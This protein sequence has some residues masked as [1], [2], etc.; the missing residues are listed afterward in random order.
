MTIT[1]K[2]AFIL[3]ILLTPFC[4]AEGVVMR[5]LATTPQQQIEPNC[6][7]SKL[8]CTV[9]ARTET[10]AS[11]LNALAA[12]AVAGPSNPNFAL[13]TIG[14][15]KPITRTVTYMTATNG[16]IT[17]N[18]AD[19][20][21]LVQDTYDNPNGWSR[22]GVKFQHVETGGQFTVVLAQADLVPTY[23]S[24]CDNVYSCTAGNYVVINQDRWLG[25]TDPWNQ[26]GGDLR[27]YRNMVV[28][29]ET[30]H[31]LGHG[32]AFCSGAGNPAPVMQQQS[33]SLQ[34]CKFNPWPLDSEIW[35]TKL[36][37]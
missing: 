12:P 21:A 7:Q 8:D 17:A 2:V 27:N 23:A 30:G 1:K 28:N 24:I 19:F 10:F 32:H 36:G 20:K 14:V 37:I 3:L 26:A 22:L 34:G 31:W 25:A 16:A 11:F 18:Y 6:E 35:S 9:A 33:I 29:H 15:R 13:P 5:A 4:L